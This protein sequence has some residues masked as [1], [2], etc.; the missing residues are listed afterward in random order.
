[1]D[2]LI[3]SRE[4]NRPTV[5]LVAMTCTAS[6][7]LERPSESAERATV[8]REEETAKMR[9]MVFRSKIISYYHGGL[10]E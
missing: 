9:D 4:L 2:A 5:V 1:M 3:L 10:N 8:R 6:S 7:G